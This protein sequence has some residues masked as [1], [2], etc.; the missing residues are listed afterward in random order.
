VQAGPLP[1]PGGPDGLVPR[2]RARP[3]S[4]KRP[5]TWVPLGRSWRWR[6][7]TKGRHAPTRPSTELIHVRRATYYSTPSASATAQEPERSDAGA[8]R[9]EQ[10]SERS[11]LRRLLRTSRG[12]PRARDRPPRRSCI[13][14]D[15]AATLSLWSS[16]RGPRL[17][18]P[19]R[20]TIGA[21]GFAPATSRVSD[22]T[23][24]GPVA[25]A[26]LQGKVPTNGTF[27]WARLVSNQRPLA[28]EAWRFW[29][30]QLSKCLQILPNSRAGTCPALGL[31]RPS[32]AGF[33]P[34]NDPTASS[35]R[36]REA[37]RCAGDDRH[38]DQCGRGWLPPGVAARKG[39]ARRQRLTACRCERVMRHCLG[40]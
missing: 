24:L 4:T 35:S 21:T 27:R 34:T 25:V 15:A 36:T 31:V 12:S 2:R 28:C 6:S 9:S 1:E 30:F 8:R 26:L 19:C 7:S 23:T 39:R 40:A 3:G 38:R 16:C 37:M 5:A 13:R 20:T 33:G 17:T 11:V 22:E 10:A 18:A 14:G 32:T 29:G